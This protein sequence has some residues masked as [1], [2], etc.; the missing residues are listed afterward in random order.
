MS[1][2]RT[3]PSLRVATI[4]F[5]TAVTVWIAGAA[6]QP[7]LVV[8]ITG[9]DDRLTIEASNT[10]I[11]TRSIV[12]PVSRISIEACDSIVPPGGSWLRVYQDSRLVTHAPLPRRFSVEPLI[13]AP[14]GDWFIDFR[15][16]HQTVFSTPVNLDQPYTI[17]AKLTGRYVRATRVVLQGSS[18]LSVLVRSGLMDE[19]LL[20]ENSE[21]ERLAATRMAPEPARRIMALVGT[22]LRTAAIALLL[23]AVF[24]FAGS[25]GSPKWWERVWEQVSKIRPAVVMAI[26]TSGFT[27]L[28]LWTAGSVL[29]RLPHTRD[30]L[31]YLLSA[32]WLL[33]GQ[34]GHVAP[35]YADHITLPWV[36]LVDGIWLPHHPLGWPAILA[37]GEFVGKG[38][39]VNPLLAP[40]WLVL[41][42]LIGRR[43]YGPG[44]AILATIFGALSPLATLIFASHLSHPSCSILLLVA[45]LLMLWIR[46]HSTVSAWPLLTLGAALGLA[47]GIRPASAAALGTVFGVFILL[48]FRRRGLPHLKVL[49]IAAGGLI[50]LTPTALANHYVTG[51]F[52]RFPYSLVESKM[53]GL[54]YLSYGIRNL[55]SQLTALGAGLHGWGWNL[56]PGTFV[57]ALGLSAAA[58]PFVLRRATRTDLFLLAIVTSLSLVHLFTRGHGLQGYG[59]RYLFEA[60]APLMLLSAR[61]ICLLACETNWPGR[62]PRQLIPTLGGSVLGVVLLLSAA[63]GIVTR[64]NSYHGYNSVNGSLEAALEEADITTGVVFLPENEWHHWAQVAAHLGTGEGEAI[65]FVEKTKNAVIENDDLRRVSPWLDWD[66]Q[67]LRTLPNSARNAKQRQ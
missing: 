44:V 1:S 43:L 3:Y 29:E 57:I 23:A 15:G 49:W 19:D 6:L 40:V 36:N 24:T 7:S 31:A 32:R 63:F 39:M 8:T 45:L 48:D 5:A 26:L 67:R 65:V 30:E 51:S 12:A 37:L 14:I 41:L 22:G 18:E 59:A 2:S 34:I 21:G 42:Y 17:K 50:A 10:V 28:S 66:G 25:L 11:E 56:V 60:V 13:P 62:R 27:A 53:L 46:D 33:D 47:F 64:L 9:A 55:D 38:W 16:P 54:G 58:V 4:Y 61:G 35:N 20:L 52:F